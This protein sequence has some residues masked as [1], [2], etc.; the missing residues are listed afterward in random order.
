MPLA[1]P[2]TV[3]V[4]VLA[5]M[6][7]WSDF[8]GPLLYLKSE[9]RYTLPVGLQILQQMDKTNWPL[10]MAAAVIMTAPVVVLFLV[11]Q[12]H[13]WP[14]AWRAESSRPLS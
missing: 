6:F 8:V 1:R 5:F 4:A 12:R 7:Y 11:V 13:F 2:T 10:L 14:E 3:A 9:S